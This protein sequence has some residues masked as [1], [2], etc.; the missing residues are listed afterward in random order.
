MRSKPYGRFVAEA[1]HNNMELP[2]TRFEQRYMHLIERPSLLLEKE[3]T[4][5]S[6]S[7]I[8]L[9][10]ALD[11]CEKNF[12]RHPLFTY[13]QGMSKLTS[14]LRIIAASRPDPDNKS[15][16]DGGNNTEVLSRNLLN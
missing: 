2:N 6:G 4:R 9:V 16:C 5:P 13:L 15:A 12:N 3:Q 1:I 7:L 14:W 8:F 10:D 11:E